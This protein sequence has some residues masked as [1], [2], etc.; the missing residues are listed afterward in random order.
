MAIQIFTNAT[1]SKTREKE[2]RRR[3]RQKSTDSNHKNVNINC[4][5][6]SVN[7]FFFLSAHTIHFIS[8][9]VFD[10]NRRREIYLFICLFT[11]FVS[12]FSWMFCSLPRNFHE[13]SFD[14]YRKTWLMRD[15]CV[16]RQILSISIFFLVSSLKSNFSHTKGFWS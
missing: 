13:S 1:K 8:S 16:T 9:K 2:I 10:L 12:K 14:S 4:W 5:L 6:L 3:N 11:I 7:F 15:L